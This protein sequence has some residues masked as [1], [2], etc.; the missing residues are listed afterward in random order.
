MRSFSDSGQNYLSESGT[1]TPSMNSMWETYNSETNYLGDVG[2]FKRVA[3]KREYLYYE[4]LKEKA[5][6]DPEQ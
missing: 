2:E 6:F 3:M 5:V 1:K 4:N